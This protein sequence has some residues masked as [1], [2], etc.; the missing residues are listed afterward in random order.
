MTDNNVRGAYIF[1]MLEGCAMNGDTYVLEEDLFRICS[2]KYKGIT[3][4]MF[5]LDLV[6]QQQQG[7]IH[8]NGNDCYLIKNWEHECYAIKKL[9]EILSAEKEEKHFLIISPDAMEENL[10]QEQIEAVNMAMSNR[11]SLIAGGAGSGK[12]TLIKSIVNSCSGQ[13]ELVL[14]APTGKAARNLTEKTGA[15]ARTIHSALGIKPKEDLLSAVL[16]DSVNI[17]I[18]DEASMVTLE[19]FSG[20]LSRVNNTCHIVFIGDSNQLKAVGAGNTFD[21]LLQLNIPRIFLTSNHRQLVTAKALIHNVTNF[22]DIKT[23]DNLAFD[24]SFMLFHMDEEDAYNYIVRETSESY[25]FSR[26]AQVLTPF[27]NKSILS[28]ESLNLGIREIKNPQINGKGEII[29]EGKVFRDGDKV[30]ISKNDTRR[31]CC[32]G[33]IG[34]LKIDTDNKCYMINLNN[35]RMP[36]W[37][38]YNKPPSLELAYAITIHKSQGSEYD[39]ILMPILDGFSCMLTRNLLYTAVSRARKG[40]LLCGNREALSMAINKYPQARRS[41]LIQKMVKH[42]VISGHVA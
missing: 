2:R 37:T 28:A 13:Y 15:T 35:G 20:L 24:E 31:H 3:R 40:I 14:C 38:F 6:S 8:R 26:N 32:N 41:G 21:D 39:Y 18:V 36:R 1:E 25:I 19:M 7:K 33:D 10:C 5:Q 34:I 9:E 17:V 42:S 23:I 30:M 16:W 22:P 12:T 11:I 27:K 29:I 4:E